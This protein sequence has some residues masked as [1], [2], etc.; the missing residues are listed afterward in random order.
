ME[1]EL[2]KGELFVIGRKYFTLLPISADVK[3]TP[4]RLSSVFLNNLE[5]FS[6][7]TQT[8]VQILD[9]CR[10]AALL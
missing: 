6:P 1:L 10:L 9:C 4:L 3:G 8:K 2:K 5:S 7:D